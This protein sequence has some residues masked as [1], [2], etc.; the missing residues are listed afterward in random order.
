MPSCLSH[1]FRGEIKL[2]KNYLTSYLPNTDVEQQGKSRKKKYFSII[3][4]VV[5]HE[6]RTCRS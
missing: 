3:R 4:F 2:S 5:L 6:E 1:F